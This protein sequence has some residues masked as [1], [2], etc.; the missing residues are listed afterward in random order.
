[1]QAFYSASFGKRLCSEVPIE[2]LEINIQPHSVLAHRWVNEAGKQVLELLISWCDRPQEEATWETYDLLA[3]QFPNF[4]LEDKA[5]YREGTQQS[6]TVIWLSI[7]TA[8]ERALALSDVARQEVTGIGFGAI[9]PRGR[10]ERY[11]KGYC[12]LTYGLLLADPLRLPGLGEYTHRVIQHREVKLKSCH[13]LA[14]NGSK[15]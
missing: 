2:V 14:S 11:E 10:D 9:C 8:V 1:M 4:R 5:F 12:L 7:C 15:I 13:A 3:D 6:S